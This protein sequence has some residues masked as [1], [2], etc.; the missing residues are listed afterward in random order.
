MKRKAGVSSDRNV[1]PL[2]Q[3]AGI[4]RPKVLMPNPDRNTTVF[5]AQQAE[6]IPFHTSWIE[7]RLKWKLHFTI[8]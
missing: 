3:S 6:F 2:I 1:T 5:E 7:D 8:Q 4:F